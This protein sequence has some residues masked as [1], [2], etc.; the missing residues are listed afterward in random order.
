MF[1]FKINAKWACRAEPR[2]IFLVVNQQIGS[3]IS[4]KGVALLVFE[5]EDEDEV[6]N[7]GAAY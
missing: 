6:I 1:P 3:N 5:F 7:L 4:R 2:Y